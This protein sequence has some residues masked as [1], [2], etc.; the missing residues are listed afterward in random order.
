MEE[1]LMAFKDYLIE[2]GY[3]EYTPSGHP[4]TVYDYIK[5]IEKVLWSERISIFELN[6]TIDSICEEYDVG[7]S[8]ENLG[9]ASHRAVINALKQYRNFIKNG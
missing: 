5:R 4:S 1:L 9:N 7:G 2:N 8:K 6:E 3:R